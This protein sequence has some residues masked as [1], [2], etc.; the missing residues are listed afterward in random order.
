M[1]E[2]SIYAI[3]PPSENKEFQCQHLVRNNYSRFFINRKNL[4]DWIKNQI[5][6]ASLYG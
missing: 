2:I 4:D 6:G 5:K 1:L 3:P